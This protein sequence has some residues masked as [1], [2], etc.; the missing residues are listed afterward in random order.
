MA[1]SDFE[2]LARELHASDIYVGLQTAV[3]G[4]M[5]WISDRYAQR[6]QDLLIGFDRETGAFD[7]TTASEWIHTM[8]LKLFPDSP[9]PDATADRVREERT[10][11]GEPAGTVGICRSSREVVCLRCWHLCKHSSVT[12]CARDQRPASALS[13]RGDRERSGRSGCGAV[14]ASRKRRMPY[15]A[16][17]MRVCR[18][19]AAAG[20]FM[21]LAGW[22]E[23]AGF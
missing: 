22:R 6:R 8:A 23:D 20:E 19:I 11:E 5:V 16:R 18:R 1:P 7:E 14:D 12:L 17:I 4:V 21:V 10:E 9:M 2:A 13:S 15:V 3:H